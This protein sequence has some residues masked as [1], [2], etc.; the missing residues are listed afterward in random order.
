MKKI[1]TYRKFNESVSDN[2][3]NDIEE[4][5]Y[6]LTD[7][8]KFKI[9]IES[10]LEYDSKKHSKLS[11]QKYRGESWIPF[12]FDEIKESVFRLKDYFSKING[13]KIVQ[14]FYFQLNTQ[15]VRIVDLCKF[16]NE[17]INDDLYYHRI[18][19]FSIIFKDE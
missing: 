13:N 10:S 9:Q 11:I 8:G 6:D 16:I 1:I 14:V 17:D 12:Y 2:I 4:I 15:Q 7:D 5:F 18:Y 19:E 3:R